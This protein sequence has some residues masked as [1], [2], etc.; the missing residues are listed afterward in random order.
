M[1]ADS[2]ILF[3]IH[4]RFD[5]RAALI[6]YDICINGSF[7]GTVKN[8]GSLT[9]ELP[10]ADSYLIEEKSTLFGTCVAFAQKNAPVLTV[11]ILT[12]GGWTTETYPVFTAPAA[13]C[14]RNILLPLP[15]AFAVI[16]DAYCKKVPI[17]SLSEKERILLHCYDFWISFSDDGSLG[18]VAAQENVV[19]MM[20]ALRTIGAVR[21]A[22]FCEKSIREVLG[23]ASLP[24]ENIEEYE[25]RLPL[26][27][28]CI[29][30]NASGTLISEM[31]L[32]ADELRLCIAQFILKEE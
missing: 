15:P 1:S 25:D 29:Q 2:S 11:E 17:D 23:D 27:D 3:H 32:F 19:E 24:L 21:L 8:G 18:E 4:R 6:P 12:K 31:E 20:T 5:L 9:V 10:T 14:G 13:E 22:D 30:H 28:E 7:V 26:L 16:R